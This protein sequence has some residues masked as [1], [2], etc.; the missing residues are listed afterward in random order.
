MNKSFI[1]N[2]KSIKEELKYIREFSRDD[3][4]VT[5]VSDDEIA[6]RYNNDGVSMYTEVY[7]I[8][9]IRSQ[10]SS[11]GI[12]ITENGA[13][14]TNAYEIAISATE[15]GNILNMFYVYYE[16]ILYDRVLL[17]DSRIFELNKIMKLQGLKVSFYDLLTSVF[18][19]SHQQRIISINN[20]VVSSM[21]KVSDSVSDLVLQIRK[22][23]LKHV[24]EFYFGERLSFIKL[25]QNKLDFCIEVALKAT[26]KF[27]YDWPNCANLAIID[28]KA[29][30]KIDVNINHYERL[31]H[32]EGI[33]M[34]CRDLRSL[35]V[36][37]I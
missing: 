7:R 25:D 22:S 19:F 28:N 2:N 18:M 1:C 9:P 35:I 14:I 6:E 27:D 21:S 37:V 23:I 20:E 30:I 8:L 26:E 31:N 34:V 36:D 33:R 17:A 32:Y 29:Y 13:E 10:R 4:Y 5:G 24:F 12:Y 3:L 15:K 11:I 16:A